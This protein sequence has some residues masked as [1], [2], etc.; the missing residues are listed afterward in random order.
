MAGPRVCASSGLIAMSSVYRH[1]YLS[2]NCVKDA[3][4]ARYGCYPKESPNKC[5][6]GSSFT[7]QHMIPCKTEGIPII[8]HNMVQYLT[9]HFLSHAYQNVQTEGVIQ[10]VPELYIF[11]NPSTKINRQAR[12]D[13][14][15]IGLHGGIM[16]RS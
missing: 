8:R 2:N 4:A 7:T 1:N 15:C 12:M 5:K 10:P 16:G 9:A 13:I 14:T 6:C 3:M 11:R